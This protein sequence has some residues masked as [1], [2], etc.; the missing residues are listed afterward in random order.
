MIYLN[1]WLS[2]IYVT[3][4][5]QPSYD[6]YVVVVVVVAAAAAVVVVVVSTAGCTQILESYGI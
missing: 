6:W 1:Y 2:T 5:P 3:L 4:T